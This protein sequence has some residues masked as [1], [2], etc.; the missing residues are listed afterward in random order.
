MDPTTSATP[1]SGDAPIVPAPP[2]PA[3]PSTAPPLPAPT[4]LTATRLWRG[5]G[6]VIAEGAVLVEGTR[7]VWSGPLDQAPPEAAARAVRRDFPGA[8]IMP[9]LIEA[10][11]HL[12]HGSP[13]MRAPGL[14]TERHQVAWD[15]LSSL[16]TARILAS[17]GVTTVQSLG[18]RHFTDVAL[19]EAVSAGVVAGPRIVASGPQI[20]TTGGHSWR[21]GGE[22]DSL[23]DIRHAVR[24]HHT[25]GVDVIKV[26]ATG[27]FMTEGTA[28]WRAQFTTQELQILVGE[29]HRLGL[30]TAAHAH[31]TEGILRA[32]EAGID[33]V[34]H[35][36]FV[37]ADGTTRF[38]PR[39]AD[40]MARRGV[41]VDTSG[42]PTYPPV[43]G[44]HF[45][46]R[47][48]ELWEHGV[49]IVVGSDIG[50]VL[51]PEAY[52]WVLGQLVASGLPVRE[53][54]VAATSRAAAA[55]GLAGVTGAL[56]P[57]YEAD[58]IVVGGDPTEDLSALDDLRLVLLRGSEFSPDQVPVW[59]ASGL[60]G[61]RPGRAVRAR[62]EREARAR[63]HPL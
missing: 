11:A 44:W 50:A 12:S 23:D 1:G 63:A 8:T 46:G 59:D 9:G 27:G 55:V 61:D 47:A 56:L 6:E 21:N 19:R 26:M 43:P 10:H 52:R 58:L 35:A 3:P 15:S 22:V 53:V 40:E 60:S 33:L 42:T 54:L 38:D 37:S 45:G 2:L 32:V 29:A 30:P 34:A 48:R 17:Q 16:H 57:G 4:L 20:T 5:T 31:G 36:S 7:I 24:D 49:R 25:W 13:P 39:L 18:A 14:A 28:P 41:F 62:Q 51:P